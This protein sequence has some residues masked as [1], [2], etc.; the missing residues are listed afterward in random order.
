MNP[1]AV[2]GTGSPVDPLAQLRDVNTEAAAGP[3]GPDPNNPNGALCAMVRTVTVLV[4]GAMVR[5][6]GEHWRMEEPIRAEIVRTNAHAIELS[7]PGGLD[8]PLIAAAFPWCLWI[9]AA[10]LAA[11]VPVETPT[12]DTQEET[13]P[14][15]GTVPRDVSTY[16]P[17]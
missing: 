2:P 10:Y 5:S 15:S 16:G 12:N 14:G 13:D 6:R 4:E 9:G 3:T 17:G 1:N 7:F 8:H 11:P